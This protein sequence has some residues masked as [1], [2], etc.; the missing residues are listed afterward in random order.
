[1]SALVSPSRPLSQFYLDRIAP[2]SLWHERTRHIIGGG[3]SKDQPE[4]ATFSVKRADG[5]HDCLPLD[6]LIR[7]SWDADT[8]CVALE[9]FSLRLTFDLRDVNTAVI[10]AQAERTYD[11]PGDTAQLNLPLVLHPGAVL[12]VDDTRHT[13][14][15]DQI[16]LDRPKS[17]AAAGWRMELPPAARFLWPYYTYNPYGEVRVPKDI[18]NALAVLSVPLEDRNWVE[19]KLTIE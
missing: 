11:R 10:R 15:E 4:L 3:N 14:G 13:L 9:G 6:G 18:R 17:I 2:V 5:S 16:A 8:L 19:V 12:T 1:M 7:G